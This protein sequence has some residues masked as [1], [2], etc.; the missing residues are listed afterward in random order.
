MLK[1]EKL[2]LIW[3][4]EKRYGPNIHSAL[5]PTPILLN[6][7]TI[8]VY[9]GC[10]D[11]IG[12]SRIFYVDLDANNPKKILNYSNGPILNVGEPGCFDENGVVPCAIIRSNNTFKMYYAGY[13]CPSRARFIAFSGLAE[14]DDGAQFKRTSRVPILE[15]SDAEP[16]FRAIHSILPE[17]NHFKIWYGAGETFIQGQ[18]KSLPIYNIRQMESK[19][20][21]SFPS[22]GNVVIN[23]QGLEYRVGRPAVYKVS[24]DF[25]V[26]FYGYG[27]EE[28]PYTLGVAKSYD[29]LTWERKDSEIGIYPGDE[30]SWDCQ[31]MA[32]PSII[33]TKNDI[34]M[35]YNGNDYGKQGFGAAKL[36]G[37]FDL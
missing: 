4:P 34:Y 19:D 21:I 13:M 14:S 23:T 22:C 11:E 17:H 36:I 28:L 27:S 15:R 18:D 12:V 16:L 33:K 24:S 1:W 3:G 6:E 8:R 35:F 9:I 25:Y 7:D 5:Q 10:R 20:A 30:G 2:G 29:G 32:Y 37:T 31:M 26:M